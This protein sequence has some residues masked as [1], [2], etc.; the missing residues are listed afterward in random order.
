MFYY[1]YYGYIGCYAVYKLYEY[2]EV[3]I[4]AYTTCSYTYSTING[5][6]KLV[7]PVSKTANNIDSEDFDDWI[8]L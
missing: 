4:F 3:I 1:I 5:V 6:Y 7:V 2:W 8:I